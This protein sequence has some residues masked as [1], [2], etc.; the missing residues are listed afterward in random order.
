MK[1]YKDL[2][3]QKL[4][5]LANLSIATLIFGQIIS[6]KYSFIATFT[7]LCLFVFLHFIAYLF[8]KE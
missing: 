7:G 8:K 3:A 6:G 5:D 2:L 1:K 4:L